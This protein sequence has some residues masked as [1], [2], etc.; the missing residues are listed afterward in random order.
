M[1]TQAREMAR[2]REKALHDEASALADA[3]KEGISEGRMKERNAMI[4]ALRASGV[5]EELIQ[6]TLKNMK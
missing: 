4:E 3:K 6:L 1:T 5:S 2:I